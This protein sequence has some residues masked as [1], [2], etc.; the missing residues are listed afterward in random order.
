MSA[1]LILPSGKGAFLLVLL[2]MP[3]LND[4][5]PGYYP[6]A[7]DYVKMLQSERVTISVGKDDDMESFSVPKALLI[8]RCPWF[9][10]CFDKKAGYIEAQQNAT[11]LEECPPPSPTAFKILLYWVFMNRLLEAA[12]DG[13]RVSTDM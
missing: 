3:D 8:A 7:H 9:A 5:E 11:R 2:P 10:P 12:S 1:V 6:S 4:P 13:S